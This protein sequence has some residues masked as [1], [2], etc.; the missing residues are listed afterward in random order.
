MSE[1][2]PS[3]LDCKAT[4]HGDGECTDADLAIAAFTLMENLENDATINVDDGLALLNHPGVIAEV[5]ARIL[6]VRTGRDG[7]GWD[8][9]G[10]NGLPFCTDKSDWLSYLGRNE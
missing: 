5:G 7:L 10:E 2:R 1:D 8:I 6:Y 9:A 4:I 3:I